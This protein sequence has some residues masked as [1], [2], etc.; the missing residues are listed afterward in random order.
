MSGSTA[1]HIE[2]AGFEA[3]SEHGHWDA[4]AIIAE[5]DAL[6]ICAWAATKFTPPGNVSAQVVSWR[7]EYL[8]AINPT[9]RKPRFT[10]GEGTTLGNIYWHLTKH[11]AHLAAYIPYS[12]TPNMDALH[13]VIKAQMVAGDPVILQVTRAYNLPRNEKGVDVHFVTLG[14]IDSTAGYLVANGDTTDALA[15]AELIVPTYWATWAQLV[16]AGLCGAIALDASY[17]PATPPVPVVTPPPSSTPSDVA[18]LAAEALSALQKLVAA[19]P[20]SR[21]S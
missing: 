21:P 5:M 12:D 11:L 7:A 16:A 6:N 18:T 13:T 4:C 10:P 3:L 1:V 9:T 20:V 15:S 17:K 2:I 14:G 8:A 19:L